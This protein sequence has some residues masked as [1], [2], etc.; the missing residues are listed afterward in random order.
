MQHGLEAARRYGAG[1]EAAKEWIASESAKLGIGCDFERCETFIFGE[2]PMGAALALQEAEAATE[3]GLPAYFTTEQ[4]RELSFSTLGACGFRDQAVFHPRKWLLGLAAVIAAPGGDGAGSYIAEHVR[5]TGLREASAVG[6]G[7]RHLVLTTRG[8]VR[9]AHVVVATHYPIFDR[10]LYFARLSPA[11][12]N[13]VAGPVDAAA[14]PRN[15]YWS[16]DTAMSVRSAPY[17]GGEPGKRLVM[18]MGQK[19]RTGED[20]DT[21]AR[22]RHLAAWG[23][24]NMGLDRLTYRWATHDLMPPD[25]L[26]Y[27]GLYHAAAQNLWV[28]AGMRQW[29]MTMGTHAAHMLASLV[30]TGK[31]E[32]AALYSPQRSAQLT[33]GAPKLLLDQLNVGRHWVIDAAAPL[34]KKAVPAAFGGGPKTPQALRPGEARVLNVRGKNVAAFRD[35]G[36]TL[37]CLGATCTHLGCTVGFNNAERSW[38]CP[39]HG[40]R[41]ALSGDILHGPATDP[42]PVIDVEDM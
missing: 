19:Y 4:L 32:D 24:A 40:S 35:E 28:C 13:C 23:K 11:R 16:A 39:C 31:H 6:L 15:A 7:N 29:G 8:E 33:S 10:G 37:H 3:A 30:C 27:V 21:L 41:F 36:G 17:D 9:A 18:V 14:A 22:F 12:D 42:L 38:D 25:G 1:Q 34:A 20:A 2:T 26:P 5:A